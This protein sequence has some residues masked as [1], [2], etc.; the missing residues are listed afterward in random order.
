VWSVAEHGP[1]PQLVNELKPLME[2]YNVAMYF[3]GH[4]HNAQ[5]LNDGSNVEYFVVGAGA[6]VDPSRAHTDDVP[7]DALKFYWARSNDRR[8]QCQEDPDAGPDCNFDATIQDGSF[9]HVKFIDADT[10][11]VELITHH[12]EVLYSL[13]K[14]NPS[15]QLDASGAPLP[16]RGLDRTKEGTEQKF[17]VPYKAPTAAPSAG[18]DGSGAGDSSGLSGIMVMVGLLTVLVGGAMVAKLCVGKHGASKGDVGKEGIYSE[19]AA[20]GGG[21]SDL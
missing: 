7:A 4:D 17:Y 20:P 2:R 14:P 6:P 15:T 10:A 3:N 8:K 21:S 5:H 16:Y 11:E 12:G 18:S 9:A 19:A 13:S 1:I